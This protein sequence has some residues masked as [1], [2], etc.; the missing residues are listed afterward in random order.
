M[1]QLQVAVG[2]IRNREQQVFIAKRRA[3]G[4]MANKWEF[5]GGKI[6]QG[7]SAE[8]GL[9]RELL[10]ETGILVTRAN[11]I[12]CIEDN[13]Q[14]D[15]LITL[16]FFLIED[17]QGDPWGKEGQ[18]T[19]WLDQADLVWQKFPPANAPIIARLVANEI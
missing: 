4:F 6:E 5:P 17:W 16:H 19:C 10:E 2:I 13:T 18:P 14:P 8:A 3:N 11:F 15:L 9:K 12:Q 7:E 1:K